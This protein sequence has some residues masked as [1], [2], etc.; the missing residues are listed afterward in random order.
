MTK[1][2]KDMETKLFDGIKYG[3]YSDTLKIY[4]SIFVKGA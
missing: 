1:V 4:P 2:L 3:G